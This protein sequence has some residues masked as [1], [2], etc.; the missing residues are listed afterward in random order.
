MLFF[1]VYLASMSR[2]LHYMYYIV[3]FSYRP[4]FV[5]CHVNVCIICIS[6]M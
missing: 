4:V 2:V 3:I 6:Y 5:H 1:I